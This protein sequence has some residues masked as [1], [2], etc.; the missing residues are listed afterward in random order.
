MYLTTL[1]IN[2]LIVLKFEQRLNFKLNIELSN[3][4][5]WKYKTNSKITVHSA[6]SLL[7]LEACLR[8]RGPAAEMAS[9]PPARVALPRAEAATWA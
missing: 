9:G 6:R 5:F 1:W 7:G 3:K 2:S 4:C 8:A